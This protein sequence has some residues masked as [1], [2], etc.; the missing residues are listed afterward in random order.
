MSLRDYRNIEY[1]LIDYFT[2]QLAVDQWAN[3]DVVKSFTEAYTT[4]NAVLCINLI[5]PNPTKKEIGSSTWL[6]NFEIVIRFFGTDDGQRLDIASWILE[7]LENSISY[8]TFTF[9]NGIAS[10]VLAG[11]IN[12]TTIIRDEKEFVNIENMDKKDKFRHLIQF[13]CRLAL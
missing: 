5:S 10:K 1:S 3:I 2:T 12:P 6:K 11:T 9:T 4:N 13:R 7:K 8:Y